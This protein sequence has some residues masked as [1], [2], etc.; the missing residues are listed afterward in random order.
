VTGEHTVLFSADEIAGVVDRVAKQIDQEVTQESLLVIAVLKG[1]TIF[2][3]DLVRALVTPTEIAFVT[4]SSYAE[5]FTPGQTLDIRLENDLNVKGRHVLIAD[6]IVDTG[7]TQRALAD[8]MVREGAARVTT[9]ALISK[10]SRRSDDSGPD[11]YG[12]EIGDELIYG[13]GMDWNERHRDLP[14]IALAGSPSGTSDAQD[15]P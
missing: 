11:H 12:F 1:A 5:D 13:Y 3:A 7:R 4:A 6:D 15:L 9:A 14:Y 2:V 10:T 8:L